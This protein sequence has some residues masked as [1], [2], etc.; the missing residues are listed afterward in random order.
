MKAS[1]NE[2]PLS[3]CREIYKGINLA[4]L[5]ENLK[6][7]QLCASNVKDGKVLDACQGSDEHRQHY[8]PFYLHSLKVT[9]VDLSK[10]GS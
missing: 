9:L 3:E 10:L 1:L 4:Q 7:S 5:P 2:L 8:S 6:Q